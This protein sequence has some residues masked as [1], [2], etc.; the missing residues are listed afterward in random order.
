MKQDPF[1]NEPQLRKELDN[2]SVN[3][4]NFSLNPNRW[5]RIIHILA[6][7]AKN[8]LEAILSTTKGVLLLKIIPIL[9][10]IF[11]GFLQAYLHFSA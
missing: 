6:S 5:E 4:P 2:Y 1:E 9:G 3:I 8:P 11:I 10:S 7:P